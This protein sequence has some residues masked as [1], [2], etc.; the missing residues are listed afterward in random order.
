MIPLNKK[1]FKFFPRL[2]KII[3]YK[4][5]LEIVVTLL[6]NKAKLPRIAMVVFIP[7]QV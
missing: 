7:R 1:L 5:R 4:T 3:D 6:E 2:N